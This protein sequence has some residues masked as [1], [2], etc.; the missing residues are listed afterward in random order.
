MEAAYQNLQYE[1]VPGSPPSDRGAMEEAAW[2]SPRGHQAQPDQFFLRFSPEIS[3]SAAFGQ[4][5]FFFSSLQSFL[6]GSDGKESACNTGDLDSI[7]ELGRS[8]GEGNSNPL[9]YFCLENPMDRRAWQLQSMGSQR[10]QQDWGLSKVNFSSN[11]QRLHRQST[12]LRVF[13]F[14]I[15][16]SYSLWDRGIWTNTVQYPERRNASNLRYFLPDIPWGFW[17]CDRTRFFNVT[18]K[19]HVKKFFFHCGKI[20]II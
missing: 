9:Q 13:K 18:L 16:F 8:P 3:S 19:D 6:G 2:D 11:C 5:V 15:F 10:V 7:L 14:G 1:G 4:E 12:S 20:H 17:T